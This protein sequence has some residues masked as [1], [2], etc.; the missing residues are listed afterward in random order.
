MY[1]YN[2]GGRENCVQC[3][4]SLPTMSLKMPMIIMLGKISETSIKNDVGY[5]VPKA[6][7]RHKRTLQVRIES[8][9]QS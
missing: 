5:I 1:M 6:V 3:L 7:C 4:F 2:S 8:M 9:Q